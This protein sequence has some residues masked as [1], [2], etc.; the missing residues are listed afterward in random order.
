MADTDL[1]WFA[2]FF[3]GEGTIGVYLL[4][5]GNGG[6]KARLAVDCT[7]GWPVEIPLLRWKGYVDSRPNKQG[8]P[9][10]RWRL[11]DQRVVERALIDLL[12]YLR[13]KGHQAELAL[14]FLEARK[15]KSGVSLRGTAMFTADEMS[16]QALIAADL[17]AAK[18]VR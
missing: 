7:A 9:M 4:G 18:R 10:V 3:D 2:G 14:R 13:V 16:A 17:K 5:R 8:T 15:A 1:V 11:Q 12:P 6:Y